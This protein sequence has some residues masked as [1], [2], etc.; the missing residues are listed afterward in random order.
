MVAM[1]IGTVLR[2]KDVC[3]AKHNGKGFVA[4][5]IVA[6]DAIFVPAAEEMSKTAEFLAK[7][8]VCFGKP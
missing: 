2:I 8:A 6:I 3:R 1:G 5:K 4:P 7:P